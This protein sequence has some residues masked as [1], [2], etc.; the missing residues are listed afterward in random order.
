MPSKKLLK[1]LFVE[2]LPSDA[3]LAIIELRKAGLN[4][5]DMRVDARD[6]FIKA[7]KEF[8][9]D[10]VISDYMMPGYNGLKALGDAREYN[11]ELPFILY[12]GSMNEEIAVECLKAG[13]DDYIIKEH[14]ARL[15][16]AIN[17]A[18]DIRLR[19][20]EKRAGELLLKEN[21]EKLQSIFSAAPVGIGLVVNRA[22]MEVNDTFCTMTGYSWKELI[23]K[24][25]EMI[26]ATKE[27]Y[28]SSGI[29]KYRQIAEKG[30]GSVK[31]RFKRKDGRI[32][33][34]ILNSAPLNKDDLL[35]G[36]TF[37]VLDITE[38]KLAV[39]VLKESEEK[40]RRIFENVQDVYFET[41][42][43]GTIHEV[44]PSIE[45]LSK[46]QYKTNDLIG[47]QM[48][49][50]CSDPGEWVALISQLREFGTVTDFEITMKNKDSSDVP[51][52]A[53]FKIYVDARGDPRKI[54][55]SMRDIT[56]RKFAEEELKKKQSQ[57]INA[58]I[59]AHLGSWEYNVEEDIFIFND[60]FY[61]LFRTTAEQ[62]GGYRM[63][64]GEYAKRFIHQDDIDLVNSETRMA[65]ETDDPNFNRQLEH[66]IIYADGE[67]GYI[68]VR[69]FI[70][71]D[72]NG[73]T[74][75]TFGVNQDITE[76][77]RAVESLR[78]S[79]L[80]FK[81]IS[82][83]SAEWI[84]EVDKNGV[85]TFSSQTVK[86]ILGYDSKDIID[87]NHFYDFFNPVV[88][89]KLKKA[90]LNL[91]KRRVGFRNFTNSNLHK[92]G[93]EVILSTS[94]IPIFDSGGNYIGFRGVDRDI[95]ES[96]NA[97]EALRKSE[98]KFRS[99]MENSA[100]A[101]FIIDQ[102]GQHQYANK[103]ATDMLGY[104]SDEILSK[105]I[106][107]ITPPD[108]IDTSFEL[109]KKVLSEGKVYAE[110][111]LKRKDGSYVAADLNSVLLPGGMVYGSCRD[112]SERKQVQEELKKSRENLEEIVYE[113]TKELNN[114]KK[115]AEKAN[116][117][118]S[119]F[120][121][122]MSHEIR[123]PMN[124]VLGYS[125][126]LNYTTVD[127]TQKDY[128]N[129]IK[130]SGKNLL[131]LINDILDLSKIEA[132]K[133]DLEYGYIDTFAFFNEFKSI[134]SL[135]IT[136][137][138]LKFIL[139]IASGTPPLIFIDEV[140]VRQIVFN[141]I[142][143]AIK[144]T[145]DG[146]IV[147]R[148]YTENPQIVDSPNEKFEELIDLIIEVED[149]GIGISKDLQNLIFEP[150]VQERK[151]KDYGGTGLGLTITKR[152]TALMHGT[153]QVQSEPGM[154]STFS[155]RIPGIVY[156]KN[157]SRTTTGTPIN[158]EEIVFEKATVIIADDVEHNRSYLRDALKNTRLK[159]VEAKDGIEAYTIAKEI[160]PDLIIADIQMPD[161][162]GFQLLDKL[163]SDEKLRKIP[164]V[165]YSASVLKAQKERIRKSEFSGLLIKPV[166]I[167][168]LYFEL[169]R[170]LPYKSTRATEPGKSLSE[171]GSIR[172]ITNLPEL[173][174]SLNTEFYTTWKTFS[175]TQPIRE[176]SDF[177]NN[178]VHLGTNHNSSFIT[179]YGK[180][181]ISA[182]N[183][184]N[185][186]AILKL[187]AGYCGI[188]EHLK[189]S[190]KEA[191]NE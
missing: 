27:E 182:A 105:T 147:L 67:T 91:F 6:E 72:K 152:L 40:Y 140:R 34:V 64:S 141:L 120:L 35:K 43:E 127:Q 53:S 18:L 185:I 81:Q 93:R 106:F 63:K 7:L 73:K 102:K 46:G 31:T 59:I 66:R 74:I 129:S 89:E 44:S 57:L 99:I 118:K 41:S 77:K 163:K 180:E 45:L 39:E 125:E 119:E 148:V 42:M 49:D 30:T 60:P 184:Y 179:D 154:G 98:E 110:V 112:I 65:I 109:F 71:K 24:S 113:R 174:H 50:F 2:D 82:E 103:A 166:E 14:P 139:D 170:F 133:L 183:S 128:I 165:A 17:E 19:E 69:I 186:E 62:V 4:F 135:K 12:T 37:I 95:T 189:E 122:N 142:G 79:E 177:G 88:G 23:G 96:K 80:R 151:Y 162:D 22:F 172:E 83:H 134:F 26:Y 143:N 68:T 52:S 187:I 107:D 15:P 8:S 150:F 164:V 137:K 70:K 160:I 33:N 97:E 173:I 178:L 86:E 3:E 126:L 94:G 54:I 11:P 38:R 76:Q 132:G 159:I 90:I 9:P 176:I 108:N 171:A 101:I 61:A 104:T 161:L 114:A 92:D 157:L 85:F 191:G 13:A 56:Y 47:R 158:P 16:F 145:S 130:S 10:I 28:E 146:R 131:T 138:Q 55:G 156:L 51:C 149:T 116:R 21:E 48:Y 169:M 1:I 155:V 29:E 87:K 168:E 75:R 32:L 117:A 136:E 167:A 58:H 100:D 36:V 153:I 181:L 144:F 121:A 5:E 123:T 115:E 190:L 111:Y 124:A 78:K 84:W 20:K 175:V 188:I 25:S